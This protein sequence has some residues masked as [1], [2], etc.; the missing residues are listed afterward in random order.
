M[1]IAQ[2]APL[3]ER[4]P[5]LSYGGIELV[6][7]RLTDELVRRGHEVTLF[8]SGDSQTLAN[9]EAVYLRALRLDQ[10]V[11]DYAVYQI[12]ELS[13][14]YQQAA[15]FDIIHSHVG[16]TALPLASLVS[17]PT[18]HTL[19]D[20]FTK[21]S[22]KVFSY[23]QNQPYVSISNAQRQINLNYVGTVY[24][25]IE[26]LDYP[27]VAQP[28]Q[29]PYLVFLGRF[30]PA[31]GPQHAIAIAKQSGWCLKMAGKVDVVDSKFF[32]QE[33]AP[34][35]DDQQIEYLG[36]INHAEKAEL[37]GNA[38]ITL[39]PITWQE[40]FG[41]VMIES[42]ATGTPVIAINLG[43]VQE[44]IAHG[45]TGFICQNY[46]EMATMIPAALKLTRQTCR[47]HVENKFSVNQMV[48]GYEAIYKQI[49]ENRINLINAYIQTASIQI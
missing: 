7:S 31:K 10:N 39:F 37:L 44:V 24:N 14:V 6:V 29:P 49:I 3:W 11:Q 18:L 2:V 12:L 38:A 30:S 43:S 41:L 28:Q 8:A 1:K 47:E 34:H 20:S 35:I 9:L 40:P 19:H 16:M 26:P 22:R 15:E 46:E 42:M 17:T 48:N 27:F 21:D 32:E 4:V 25:G 13:Q 33:I 23:H 45:I 5:P 36:E